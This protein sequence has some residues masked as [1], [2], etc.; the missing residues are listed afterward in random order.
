M[1]VGS[2]SVNEGV[3]EASILAFV[4]VHWSFVVGA[5]VV[6]RESLNQEGCVVN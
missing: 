5:T 3:I 6:I 2:A 1:T 4:F